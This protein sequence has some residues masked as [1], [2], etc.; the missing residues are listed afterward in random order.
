[1]RGGEGSFVLV[2]FGFLETSAL[3]VIMAIPVYIPTLSECGKCASNHRSAFVS[4]LVAVL[5]LVR[6]NHKAGSIGYLRVDLPRM[7]NEFRI[8]FF[9][10]S[11]IGLGGV[12]DD[13]VA[14]YYSH[15]QSVVSQKVDKDVFLHS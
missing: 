8:Q 4:L 9:I 6:W 2:P 10:H 5:T 11:E 14:F 15:S 1:M 3:T 13:I 12:H 7:L